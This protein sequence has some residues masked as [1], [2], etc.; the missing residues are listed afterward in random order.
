MKINQ[1]RKSYTGRLEKP[2]VLGSNMP[3][4]IQKANLSNLNRVFCTV[5]AQLS[6]Y[7]TFTTRTIYSTENIIGKENATLL[8]S[9][10]H[11]MP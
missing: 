9:L 1:V 10:C 8:F 7:E 5:S 3:K 2:Q 11:K 4:K 6:G